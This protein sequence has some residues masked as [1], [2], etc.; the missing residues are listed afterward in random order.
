[1][2]L[3]SLLSTI[4]LLTLLMTG[5]IVVQRAARAVAAQHPEAG[6]LRLIG[7]GCG[8]QGHGDAA[9]PPVQPARLV[10]PRRSAKASAE[11]CAGCSNTDCKPA[12]PS[13]LSA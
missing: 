1:M 6:P 7:C 12:S 13:S 5:W 9:P 2:M 8:G 3:T 11:G 10:A 4:V